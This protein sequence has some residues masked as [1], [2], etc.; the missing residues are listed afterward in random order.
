MAFYYGTDQHLQ[1]VSGLP[2]SA[3][4][5]LG[6]TLSDLPGRLSSL[7]VSDD[8][9]VSLVAFTNGESG[10]VYLVQPAEKR[11]LV[12]CRDVRA[13]TFLTNSSNA[14]IA[15][16][17]ANEVRLVNDVTGAA[18]TQILAEE[19]RG[20]SHPLALRAVGRLRRDQAHG[21]IGGEQQRGS[22]ERGGDE[23]AGRVVADEGPHEMGR[24]E[25]DEADRAGDR[26]RGARP[27]RARRDDD[28]PRAPDVHA[29]ARRR[30]L[31]ERERA[32]GRPGAKQER[33]G[34]DEER[35]AKRTCVM[36][37]SSS[38]PSSQNTISVT[39]KG[40]GDR[41]MASEVA[42][43]ARLP[44]ASPASTSTT[45]PPSRP[46]T[47]TTSAIETSAPRIAASGS[48]AGERTGEPEIE[49]EHGP[50]RGRLRRAEH[51]R[52]GERIAQQPLQR[53]AGDAE[54][55][56]RSGSR[57]ACAAGGSPAR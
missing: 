3:E 17:A 49:H 4:V 38:E 48:A 54:R 51:R 32:Q 6:I 37:R 47:A 7:A 27:E 28:E 55:R 24:D 20:I 40:F 21:A 56:R 5:S 15:D 1:I 29:E 10:A 36:A 34:E 43:P 39:A 31:A 46:A 2:D 23:G 12:Q 25:P 8:G 53:R 50:E 11:V 41:L 44:M 57:A 52:V 33:A 9:R 35:S 45:V 19:S 22:G 42:A 18:T 13:M 26:D 14:V 16:T 30:L